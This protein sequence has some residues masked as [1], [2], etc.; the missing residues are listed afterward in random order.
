MIQ[1]SF[2]NNLILIR[3]VWGINRKELGTLLNCTGNQIA[4]YERGV[5]TIPATLLLALEAKTG[6]IPKRL[7]FDYL[8][9]TAIPHH[10]LSETDDRDASIEGIMSSAKADNLSLAARVKR[11][12]LSVFGK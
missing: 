7:Y 3:S 9:R 5:M 4:G 11:L 2:S 8:P 6:I 10:P 12:E 1:E